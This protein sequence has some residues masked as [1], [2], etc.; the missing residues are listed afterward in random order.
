MAVVLPLIL[1]GG[2]A[3]GL[4]VGALLKRRNPGV[5]A[6]VGEGP[7]A[8]AGAEEPVRPDR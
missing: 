4:V 6:S 3:V 8:E 5:F 1:F 7:G 2:G